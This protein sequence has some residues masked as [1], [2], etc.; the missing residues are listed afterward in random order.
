L[1]EVILSFCSLAEALL[2]SLNPQHL[3]FRSKNNAEH[4]AVKKV[5]SEE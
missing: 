5:K 3:T 1:E 2:Y 4:L